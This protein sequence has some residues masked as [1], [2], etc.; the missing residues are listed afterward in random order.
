MAAGSSDDDGQCVEQK[1]VLGSGL[2]CRPHT[3]YA[4]RRVPL[5][6]SHGSSINSS[7]NQQFLVTSADESVYKHQLHPRRCSTNLL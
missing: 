5:L 6:V 2:L 3:V 4:E 1:S 7:P